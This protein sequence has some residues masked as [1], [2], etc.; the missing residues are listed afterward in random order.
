MTGLGKTLGGKENFFCN[1][2]SFSKRVWIWGVS[3]YS[4]MTKGSPVGGNPV[5]DCPYGWL[6]R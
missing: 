4:V 3:A 2:F 6:M 5:E 1:F